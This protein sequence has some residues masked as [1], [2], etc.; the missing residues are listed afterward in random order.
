[1][2]MRERGGKVKAML[3]NN[4]DR[5][6]LQSNIYDNVEQGSQLYTDE[7]RAYFGID[8]LYYKHDVVNHSAKEFINGMAHTNG[9][10][11]VWAVLKRGINGI[12]HNVSRKHLHRYVNEFTFRLNEGNCQIDMMDRMFALGGQIDNKRL[13]YKE[14]IG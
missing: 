2:G 6:T 4:T 12:F 3:V 9:I 8:G 14:L 13:S 1:M 10:E 7:H 5:Q 11:S